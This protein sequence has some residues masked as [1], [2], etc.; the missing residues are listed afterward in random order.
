VE[1]E[2]EPSFGLSIP[3]GVPEVPRELLAPRNAWAD[4]T[5]YD[6]AAQELSQRFHRNFEK[7]EA[8]EEVRAAAP[9]PFSK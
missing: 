7:F 6:Q 1:F 8:P 3:K 5:A 9:A 4:K 2:V